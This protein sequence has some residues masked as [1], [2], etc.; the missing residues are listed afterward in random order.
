MEQKILK[1]QIATIQKIEIAY[2][3]SSDIALEL[4]QLVAVDLRNRECCGIV[5]GDSQDSYSGVTKKISAILPYK[6]SPQYIKFAEFVAFY[7]IAN[8]ADV[9]KLI[10]QFNIKTLLL[11]ERALKSVV[12]DVDATIKLSDDQFHAAQKMKQFVDI[13]KVILLHGITGSGKTEVFLEFAVPIV[14]SGKQILI[15]VPEVSLSIDLAKK[16]ASKF[17]IPVYVWHNSISRGKKVSIWKKAAN[18]EPMILVGARSALFVPFVNLGCIVV[19]EEH[20][21]SFKQ[22]EYVVY[23]ARD[24]AIYLASCLNIPIVLSSATPS[25]ESFNNAQNEKYEY[26]VLKSRY[27]QYA[28]LPDIYIDDMKKHKATGVL[29]QHS[30][31]QIANCLAQNK[32]ALIF[33]NRRGHTPKVLC[34]S[35]GAKVE[36]PSCS[37]WLCY[38]R[39]MNQMVCHYCGFFSAAKTVCDFCQSDDIVGIGDGI[40]KVCE[41]VV[42]LFPDK[43]V[44][45]LS[46]DTMNTQAKISHAIDKIKNSEVDIILGTQIISKGHN[47]HNLNLVIITCID[48]ML[49]GDDFRSTEKAFQLMHQ[50]SGRAG[51]VG[52]IDSNAQVVIQTYNPDD[53]LMK[54][55]HTNNIAKLYSTE[56]ANRKLMKMPPFGKLV[57]IILSALS[58]N[59]VC[60]FAKKFLGAS[61]AVPKNGKKIKILGPIQPPMFKLRSR[62][63]LRILVM[64]ESHMQEYI[65]AWVKISKIPKNIKITIDVDPHDFF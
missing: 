41:E 27:F 52:S 12:R 60:Y 50:V 53:E 20:D 36:C 48:M 49:Y 21:K 47:F 16:V 10:V 37:A 62:Y 58:E 23:H 39:N 15:L 61:S 1:Y 9:F 17:R 46:S 28:K 26:I 42:K 22:N 43:R 30:I 8:I 55:L 64:S 4:G 34:H 6:I 54:I 25:V 45:G 44:M 40:E 33:V 11:P 35:C 13:F 59:E 63:R 3:Y 65:K 31:N 5:V 57:S 18:G 51:R 56:I 29:S 14:E 7:N 19:D 32:Q 24:M 38:H 2:T